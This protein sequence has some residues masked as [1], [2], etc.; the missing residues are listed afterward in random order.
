MKKVGSKFEYEQERNKNLL[1]VYHKLI[2]QTKF[3]K[4]SELY[5][6]MS[7]HPSERFW[8]SEE[9]T[10]IVIAKIAK[11]D[12]LTYMKKNKREMF[13]ELYKRVNLMR[14]EHPQ[15]PF[16]K[17]VFRVIRQ[18]APR[19]Y[20]TEESIKVIM[21]KIKTKWYKKKLLVYQN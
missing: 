12:N 10:A 6:N 15:M 17:I 7:I 1:Q 2:S 19:F 20:L 21:S 4:T 8:V 11:G 9:R 18:P 3:I 5:H 16:N 14:K 13:F